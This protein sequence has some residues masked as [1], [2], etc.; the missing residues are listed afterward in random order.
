[1]A[2]NGA[3]IFLGP[4]GAGKGT[5]SKRLAKVY[6]VPHLST[7]EMLRDAIGRKTD[8]GLQAGPLMER[9]ELVPDALVLALVEERVARPDAK[10]GFIFDGFPRTIPQAEQLDRILHRLGFGKPVVVEFRVDHDTLLRRV[11]GRWTCPI[12]GETYNV[13]ER[14]PKVPGI[15]DNDGGQLMQRDDDRAEI[16]TERLAT[17]AKQTQPLAD[18]YRD[19]GV[20]VEIDGMRDVE[21]VHRELREIVERTGRRDGDL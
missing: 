21:Q 6:G 4:P 16:V 14:P 15:C 2:L 17:Y 9:G 10:A 7:G 12:G 1:M 11:A 3:L 20:L 13:F 5:Q 19:H 8:L 18:Y